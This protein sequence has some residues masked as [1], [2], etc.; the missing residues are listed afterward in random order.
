MLAYSP[1]LHMLFLRF[2]LASLTMVDPSYT[3]I[4]SAAWLM[5]EHVNFAPVSMIVITTAFCCA[6]ATFA[7]CSG[8]SF[9]PFFEALFAALCSGVLDVPRGVVD[10]VV[11]LREVRDERVATLFGNVREELGLRG[12]CRHFIHHD[13]PDFG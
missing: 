5:D 10:G 8:E 3:P 12:V 9:F 6:A 2:F 1:I 4:A 7:M 13:H 11:I